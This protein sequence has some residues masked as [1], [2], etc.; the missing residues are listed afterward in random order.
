M[1][2]IKRSGSE[3]TFDISKIMAAV[4]KANM[5]VV[6]S[7][8]LSE[9]QIETI[10][11]NV[12]SICKEMNRSLSV[13][14]I[15]DLVENQIMNLRAFA[16]ARKYITYRFQR[17]L[18]RQSNTTD[19]QI[20][21]LIE[22][23]NEEVKDTQDNQPVV[24]TNMEEVQTEGN[25][26][27]KKPLIVYF[28]Y[29]ENSELPQDVDA[30]ASASIQKWND[31]NTGNT[32]IV[33]HIIQEK[34]KGDMFSVQTVNKYPSTYNEIVNQGKQEHENNIRPELANHI[35]NLDDYDTIFVGYPNWW[36]DM[37]MAMYS[38]FDEYDLSNKTI[39]P[40]NTSGGSAFS[41]TINT[42]KKLEPNANVIEGITIRAEDVESSQNEIDEWLNDLGY[43]I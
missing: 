14:E 21:S 20:L 5:E 22:C 16:V 8:R 19:D 34:T 26:N 43:N 11:N 30:S 23:A 1:K 27:T 33:A 10:S 28:S 9:E 36:Y 6:H 40:F 29:G 3:V 25:V 32:G 38:F 4:S 24:S 39:I 17:A 18:A 41:D 31:E 15:Q 42:I 13:E 2:I 37:P 12:E 7:E 35:T